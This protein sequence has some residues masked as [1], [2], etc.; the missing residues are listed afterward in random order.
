[1]IFEK[2]QFTDGGPNDKGVVIGYIRAPSKQQ[3]AKFLNLNHSFIELNKVT[4][5]YFKMKKEAALKN[6]N[7]LYINVQKAK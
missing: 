4:E 6:Y 2:R 7:K 5:S 1:M 3:A